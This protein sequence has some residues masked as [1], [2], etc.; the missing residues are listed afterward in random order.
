MKTSSA[1]AKGRSLQKFVEERIGKSF[2]LTYGKDQDVESRGMGQHGTDIRLTPKALKR[3]PFSVECKNVERGSVWSFI[4]Q[5]RD[6]QLPNT[7][8][9][10]V[11]K[12]NRTKPIVV[13]DFETF[14]KLAGGNNNAG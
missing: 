6:N 12:R 11:W 14:I 8:W 4:E 13:M 5:A 2:N 7:D 3:F 10:V 1:K 9:L